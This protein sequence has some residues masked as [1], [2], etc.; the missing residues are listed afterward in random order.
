MENEVQLGEY[1]KERVRTIDKLTD[2][3]N[4]K[5]MLARGNLALEN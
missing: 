1:I 5:R 2:V 4:T 3:D